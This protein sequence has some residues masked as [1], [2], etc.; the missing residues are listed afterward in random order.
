MRLVID[1]QGAQT[2]SRFRG[3][4]RYTLALTQEMARQRGENEILLALNA[5]YADTI[6]PI[7]AAFAD[8]L[9]PD[10]IKVYEVPSPVCGRDAPNDARRLVAERM[11]EAYFASLQAD[12]IFI[13]SLFEEFDGEAVTSVHALHSAIPTAVTLHDLIPLVHRDIYLQDPAMLRWYYNKIDHLRRA[14]LL[15]AV[16]DASGREAV[17]YLTMPEN[18]VV[19]VAN[20]CDTHFHPISLNEAQRTHLAT[21]YGIN[22]PF[23]MNTGGVDFRK[24][25]DGLFRAFASLTTDVRD[26]YALAIV[27]R[28]A[29][30]LKND[31]LALA[32]RSGL[33]ATGLPVLARGFWLAGAGGHGLR[34]GGDCC[35]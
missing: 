9:P 22:R 19:T 34:Y 5:A 27:G 2:A 3:I 31:F 13:P 24:N 14:D 28:E 33:Q 8:L 21:T 10:A 12:I 25:M 4:G 23:I 18:S 15:L 6:E 1:M 32:K 17:Q 11:V 35:Q 26:T 20:A 29:L 7:R 30:D 16:S